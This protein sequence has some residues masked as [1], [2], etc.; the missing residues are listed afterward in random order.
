M[1]AGRNDPCP[2][3]SGRKYKKCCLGK[4]QSRAAGTPGL[5]RQEA[6]SARNDPAAPAVAPPP[7]GTAQP[8]FVPQAQ[9][10]PTDAPA[11]PTTRS[12][13]AEF[14]KHDYANRALL[15]EQSVREGPIDAST[16]RDMLALLRD[17]CIR[18][19]ERDRFDALL[20]ALRRTRPGVYEAHELEYVRWA[21]ADAVAIPRYDLLGVRAREMAA[22]AGKHPDAFRQMAD[23][24]AYH[25]QLDILLKALR[26]AWRQVRDSVSP[27][28]VEGF[29]RQVRDCE[30]FDY[31]EHTRQPKAKDKDLL[32]RLNAYGPDDRQ[33]LP[34]RIAHLTGQA[35]VRTPPAGAGDPQLPLLRAEFTGHLRRDAHLSWCRADL[36]A[37]AIADCLA[38][39]DALMPS[40][41]A[42]DACLRRLLAPPAPLHYAAA[43]CLEMLPAWA[44]F[45]ASVELAPTAEAALAEL[46]PVCA[47]ARKSLAAGLDDRVPLER[48]DAAW[49]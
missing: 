9:P 1:K 29:A 49:A 16:A 23:L 6:K 8:T 48:L 44:R 26:V 3:G 36:A 10:A 2:C 7:A 32:A 25:D 43:A 12:R 39:G 38:G 33:D 15:F 11:P 13:L 19:N 37:R 24:L 31:L 30:L 20:A 42:L 21:I 22:M 4:D 5:P 41:A 46:T 35:H 18:R 27:P 17:E 47:K 14:R 28:Q 34:G 40:R 45:L